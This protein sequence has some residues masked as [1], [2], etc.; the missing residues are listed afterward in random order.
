M[1][2]WE[3]LNELKSDKYEWVDLSMDVSPDTLHYDGFDDLKIKDILNFEEHGAHAREFTL[4]SQYGTHI[5]PP[6]HF[7]P[8]G[9]S[10][11]EIELLELA[12]PLCVIDVSKQA[13]ENNDFMLSVADIELWEQEN[14]EI[15]PDS[16]VAMRTDWSKRNKNDFF[17][18]DNNGDPHYPGW[19]KAALRYL[20]EERKIGAIGHEPPDTDPA[21]TTKTDLWA[22]ELHYL[23]QDKYQIE[24]LTNLDQLPAKGAIIFCTFPK[25]VDAP[26]FSAR[27]FAIKEK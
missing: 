18:K 22:G 10:L 13:K 26:G 27:C 3:T 16:F 21:F 6:S 15:P 19:S 14:G 24:M 9:R 25:I 11:E 8:G 5:D 1:K 20:C 17:N 12:Y 4:V 7:V 2:L 23:Q